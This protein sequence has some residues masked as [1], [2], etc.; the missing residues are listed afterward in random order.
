VKTHASHT[1]GQKHSDHRLLAALALTLGFAAIEALGGWWSHSLALLGDAG[2][3]VTDGV[4]LGGAVLAARMAARPPSRHH[5]YGLGRA[6]VV[7]ALLNGLLQSPTPVSGGVVMFVAAAGLAAN[8]A[9]ALLL[10]SGERTLNVRGALLHVMGDVLGSVAALVSGTVI[11]FTG[12][13]PIDALVSLLICALIVYSSFRLVRDAL[14]VLME[15]VP[16]HLDLREVGRA[17]AHVD[18]RVRSVHDLHIWSVSSGVVALSAHVVIDELR[19]WDDVLEKL[20]LLLQQ[21]YRIEHVTLQPETQVH[22][23][24]PASG[25]KPR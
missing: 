4:A 23:L 20:R 14:H 24:R 11:H 2:H 10:S 16:P 6:E 25:R 1:H 15:G 9:V 12:W 19:S 3:M 21:R 5:S 17:M 13:T 18:G 22:V 8:I 7:A